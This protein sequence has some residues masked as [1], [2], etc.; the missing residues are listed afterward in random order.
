MT[1]AQ[2]IA[3]RS[4]VVQSGCREWK[5]GKSKAGYGQ[6]RS[7]GKVVYAHRASF[8][9][10]YGPLAPGQFV[11]HKCD[12]PACVEPSHLFAGTQADNMKDCAKKGRTALNS[13]EQSGK[14]KLTDAAAV[15]IYRRRQAGESNHK[16]AREFHIDPTV[17][18]RIGNGLAWAHIR[19]LVRLGQKGLL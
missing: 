6:L 19:S 5:A 7:G 17:V 14:A 2:R 3:A 8:E 16:L 18:S 15:E 12:N 11:C 4:E 9:L 1:L 10:A 13:G